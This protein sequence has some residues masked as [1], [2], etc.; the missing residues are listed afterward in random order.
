MNVRT[1]F[2]EGYDRNNFFDILLKFLK[3]FEEA[4]LFMQYRV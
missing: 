3:Y 4:L 1:K 2:N